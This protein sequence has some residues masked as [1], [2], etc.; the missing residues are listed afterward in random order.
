MGCRLPPI[1][2]IRCACELERLWGDYLSCKDGHPN[3]VFGRYNRAPYTKYPHLADILADEPCRPKYWN[4]TGNTYCDITH[5][6]FGDAPLIG[7]DFDPATFASAYGG[8]DKTSR[9]SPAELRLFP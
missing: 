7:G 4:L 5:V 8:N 1:D 6:K 2:D 9:C 3:P